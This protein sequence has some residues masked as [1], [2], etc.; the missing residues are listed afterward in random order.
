QLL[1]TFGLP[2]SLL[3]LHRLVDR[4]T[5]LRGGALSAALVVQGLACAYYGVFAG[6]TVGFGVI[7]YAISP[8]LWES[9]RYWFAVLSA[10]ALT[11]AV[12]WP[13]F[14][15]Y[16]TLQEDFG[17]TRTLDDAALYSADWRAWLA[18]SAWAH[19]WMLPLLG[20]WNEVLFPGALTTALGL[21]GIWL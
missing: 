5:L 10:A 11:V 2:L 4:P 3:A 1:L 19:R 18:S 13:F 21:T 16:L 20:H 6:L 17:F 15:P 9:A 8:G 14:S 12:L 7:Y